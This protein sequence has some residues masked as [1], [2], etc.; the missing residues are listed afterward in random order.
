MASAPDA[1]TLLAIARSAQP[2]PFLENNDSDTIELPARDGWRVRFFYDV[3]DFDYI[4]EFVSPRGDIIDFWDW[5]EE[6][7]G[8]EKLI[9]CGWRRIMQP[10]EQAVTDLVDLGK[11][12]SAREEDLD[13]RVDAI[14]DSYLA[15][16]DRSAIASKRNELADAFQ[17][18]EAG[19]TYGAAAMKIRD[20]ILRVDAS[21]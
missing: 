3:G 16:L 6:T 4:E 14:V 20:R 9:G 12:A 7:P 2:P 17:A 5:P 11:H 19:R 13:S 15:G 10:F 8:R 21:K 1:D 18:V